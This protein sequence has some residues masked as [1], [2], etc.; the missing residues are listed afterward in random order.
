MNEKEM[1][2]EMRRYESGKL[3][4]FVD[5]TLFTSYGELTLKGFRIIQDEQRGPWVAFPS[6]VY[7]KDGNRVNKPLIE[8]SRSMRRT[9]T[10]AVLDQ[11]K[12]NQ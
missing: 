2:I 5:L 4:A 7:E 1:I 8:M 9:V 12:N 11:F 3:K 6:H 10:E